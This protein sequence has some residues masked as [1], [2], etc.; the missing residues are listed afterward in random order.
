MEN[1]EKKL[2]IWTQTTED[3]TVVFNTDGDLKK[4]DVLMSLSSSS[5]HLSIK[6]RVLLGGKLGGRID[7]SASSYTIDSN[8]LDFKFSYDRFTYYCDR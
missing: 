8:K 5:I 1:A 3:I 4:S 6:G 2:F 7:S